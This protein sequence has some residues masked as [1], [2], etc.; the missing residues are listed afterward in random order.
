MRCLSSYL[1]PQ[2]QSREQTLKSRGGHTI[3]FTHI[4]YK[5]S[6]PL[7]RPM[8]GYLWFM[9]LILWLLYHCDF[10]EW[11]H[12]ECMNKIPLSKK[13]FSFSN[14]DC[15]LGSRRKLNFIGRVLENLT[16]QVSLAHTFIFR[17]HYLATILIFF[18]FQ[19]V[20]LI[21]CSHCSLTIM[22]QQLVR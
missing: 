20:L 21:I 18:F 15:G 9:R 12:F 13:S 6:W 14:R 5:M 17:S 19:I 1:M 16:T 11:S 7:V 3:H 8:Y 4:A 22:L 10:V 2:L